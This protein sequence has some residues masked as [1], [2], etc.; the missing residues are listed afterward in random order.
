MYQ[1]HTD[2]CVREAV[3]MSL[4]I[5]DVCA[6]PYLQR[7]ISMDDQSERHVYSK[8]LRKNLK[9]QGS[10]LDSIYADQYIGSARE[11]LFNELV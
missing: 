3:K 10:K 1:K 11:K 5:L 4:Y 6:H 8:Q 7:R 2:W 9:V